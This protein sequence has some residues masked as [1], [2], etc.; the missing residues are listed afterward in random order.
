[1][2]LVLHNR[3]LLAPNYER[4]SI[5]KHVHCTMVPPCIVCCHAC[6]A[7]SE[8]QQMG[9]V[10]GGTQRI[11]GCPHVLSPSCTFCPAYV[12]VALL[13]MPLR[14]HG[15]SCMSEAVPMDRPVPCYSP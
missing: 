4:A 14:G 2:L 1:M 13:V 9:L 7:D 10:A 15:H 12:L 6:T 5:H 8:A 11:A 3:R